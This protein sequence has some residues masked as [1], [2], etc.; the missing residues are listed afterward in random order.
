MIGPSRETTLYSETLVYQL[1][2]QW[3]VNYGLPR[4]WNR[5]NRK[6]RL[7]WERRLTPKIVAD[8][9]RKLV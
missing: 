1:R 7:K 4:S 5:M 8:D 9:Y 2:E 6:R 3:I